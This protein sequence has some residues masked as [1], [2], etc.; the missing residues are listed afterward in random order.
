MRLA[1]DALDGDEPEIAELLARRDERP[2]RDPAGL[3]A[4]RQLADR[5]A[6]VLLNSPIQP[7]CMI[8]CKHEYPPLGPAS[9]LR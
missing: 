9:L 7:L 1:R 5:P 2:V 6:A 4:Q 8:R 3:A